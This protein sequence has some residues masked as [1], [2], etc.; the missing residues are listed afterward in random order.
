MTKKRA[1][2]FSDFY[3]HGILPSS[4]TPGKEGYKAL[5]ADVLKAC[6][7]SAKQVTS[8]DELAPWAANAGSMYV[9]DEDGQ[10]WDLDCSCYAYSHSNNVCPCVVYMAAQLKF[11]DLQALLGGSAPR[12]GRGR[13]RKDKGWSDRSGGTTKKK[14][15]AQ[16]LKEMRNNGTMRLWRFNALLDVDGQQLVGYMKTCKEVVAGDASSR[17]YTFALHDEPDKTV[18]LNDI[19]FAQGIVD[20]R[21]AAIPQVYQHQQPAA[22]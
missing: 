9:A 11:V 22:S 20:A 21:E 2:A 19:A 16:W 1:K 15:S 7:V 6:M 4:T 5:H 18:V 12:Q 10:L 17:Q 14:T 13:P 3:D 8:R